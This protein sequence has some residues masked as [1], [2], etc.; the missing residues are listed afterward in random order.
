MSEPPAPGNARR[1]G[2]LGV[3]AASAVVLAAVVLLAA[4]AGGWVAA[5]VAAV[6]AVVVYGEWVGL[7]ARDTSPV[8]I[9]GA[10]AL[11]AASVALAAWRP[12]WALGV[13]VLAMAV[14]AS[15]LQR[16]WLPAGV[17]YA[18]ALGFGLV[19]IRGDGNDGLA[20]LLF[21]FA[22]VWSADTGAYFAGRMLGG[23][24]LWPRVSPKKTW[25]GFVG[26]LVAG[27]AG[28]LAVAAMFKQP[29]TLGLAAIALVLGAVS[30]AGDLF[31]SWIKRRAGVKDASNL[32]PG[33]G[34]LMDRVDGLIFA[35]GLALLVG[36]A[37]SGVGD[38]G[39]GLLRW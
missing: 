4:W 17:L 11:L 37:H 25:S 9:F 6:A 32:I 5:L 24:K 10:G 34:G 7:T 20:A 13:L 28:G 29:P 2:D 36:L 8:A 16:F 33:H 23:P 26:G 30:V 14:A 35:A 38:I 1:T 39:G 31:E 12:S 18:A 19:L 15:G 21:V 22:V 3:R 27:V